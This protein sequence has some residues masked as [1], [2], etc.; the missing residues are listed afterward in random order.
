[1]AA[2]QRARLRP[3]AGRRVRRCEGGRSRWRRRPGR[4]EAHMLQVDVVKALGINRLAQR[5]RAQ[6]RSIHCEE[7]HEQ[8]GHS[9]DMVVT[10]GSRERRCGGRMDNQPATLEDRLRHRLMLLVQRDA[11]GSCGR[12]LSVGLRRAGP[13]GRHPDQLARLFFK[14]GI[15]RACRWVDQ[16]QRRIG[17]AKRLAGLLAETSRMSASARPDASACVTRATVASR[18]GSSAVAV[19]RGDDADAAPFLSDRL[20]RPRSARP[21]A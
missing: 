19:W 21:G 14:R 18:C 6:R 13:I 10:P 8:R 5:Q 3:R 12:S 1:M 15:D 16:P 20:E 7:R 2:F 4:Q 9:R 11:R 17:H